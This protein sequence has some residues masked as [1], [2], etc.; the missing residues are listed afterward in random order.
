MNKK[1]A[2]RLTLDFAMT[3]L[4]LCALMYRATGDAAHE[5]IGVAVCAVCIIHNIL[6]WKWYKNIFKGAYNLR[7][8]VLTA[9]NLL[10]V[11][12]MAALVITGLLH[13]RTVLAF[14]HLP[15][16]MLIRQI[17]TT[18]AYWC[19]PLIGAHL[20]LHWSIIINAFRKMA[21]INGESLT[22]KITVRISAFIVVAF[23]V[24][25][26]FDRDMFSK[27]FLGFSFDYW[28]EERPAFLF[29][30]VNLS[31]MGV[32]VFLTYYALK[33]FDWLCQRSILEG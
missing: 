11:L 7:R 10:L 30:A 27:L 1:L 2:A 20:G 6:N 29:F 15:G 8:S 9:I 23:G 21:M 24:W 12:A 19:L 25:S 5:W 3:V 32:Y 4:L 17:H 22:R 28:P 16:D 26:S 13:S 18:A 31:I 14:L 33:V